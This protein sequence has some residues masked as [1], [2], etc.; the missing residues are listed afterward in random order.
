[1]I[2]SIKNK[3]KQNTLISVNQ[4]LVSVKSTSS[5]TSP[6]IQSQQNAAKSLGK[7]EVKY[8]PKGAIYDGI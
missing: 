1:M 2:C 3:T 8:M 5:L 6:A 7:L 4:K